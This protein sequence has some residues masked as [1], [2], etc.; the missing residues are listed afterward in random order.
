MRR[1]ADQRPAADLQPS[2]ELECEEQIC[3]FGLGVRPPARVTA[4]ALQVVELHPPAFVVVAADS[5]DASVGLIKNWEQESSQCEVAQ[6]I[7]PELKLEAIGCPSVGRSHHAGV[8]DQ[9]VDVLVAGPNT[10]GKR[11]YRNEVG[12]VEL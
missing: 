8:I 9:Q 7:G 11:P 12:K 10:V 6:M 2:V 3:E 1:D 4:L 5:H